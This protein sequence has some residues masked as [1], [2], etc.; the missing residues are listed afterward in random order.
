MR[1]LRC[2]SCLSS[3]AAS[4]LTLPPSPSSSL[5][6]LANKIKPGSVPKINEPATMPF[7]KMENIANYLKAVRSLGMKEFEMFGTPDLFD[8]KNVQQ[9]VTSTHALGRLL[10]T[11]MPNAPF[12]KLG[13]KVVEKNERH[14]SEDQLRQARMAVSVLNLGSS[15]LGKKA[16]QD[17]LS[18][19]GFVVSEEHKSH[20]AHKGFNSSTDVSGLSR[21]SSNPPVPAPPPPAPPPPAPAKPALPAGWEELTTDDGRVYYANE[22]TGE[23]SW[24]L[25]TES[26]GSG[27]GGSDLPPG[28]E[29]L[30]TDDGR[31]YYANDS[32]GETSW[33]KPTAGGDGL[34]PGWEELTTD[35]G[36]VYY[37]N[38]STGETAWEKPAYKSL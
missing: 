33:D 28:W 17:V 24:D 14:F 19:D 5:R 10:Q 2:A 32:T 21:K 4:A 25:P 35:D 27:S 29:E 15:D 9:V 12:P 36:R 37:A 6:R 1:Q 20:A 16:F 30:T 18:G 13:I 38:E 23:T 26:S 31:V 34:P 8:E 22:S 11:I 3:S 7:K